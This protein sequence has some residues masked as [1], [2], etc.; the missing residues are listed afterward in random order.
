[1]KQVVLLLIIFVANI[2]QGITGFAGTVLA[3]PVSILL[4]GM[5]DAKVILSFMALFSC[6]MITIQNWKH[7]LWKEVLR[8]CTFMLL[9]MAV[10]LVLY[11]LAPSD[12]LLPIYGILVTLIGLQNLVM[13]KEIPMNRLSLILVLFCAG[14]IHGM[15]LSG[16]ALLVIYATFVLKD[17]TE[18]RATIAPIWVILNTIL[19]GLYLHDGL[20]TTYNGTLVLASII[21]L[22]IATFLGNRLQKK[23]KQETF[24]KL[25]YILLIVSG[26]SLL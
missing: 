24:L 21:P 19:I 2:I 14:I 4:I 11:D 6:L 5:E 3:M 7:V 25:T 12:V 22:V 18:F 10:G 20:I 17:K 23:M 13:K 26:V 15:F 8:I 16:G 9:G 1:M